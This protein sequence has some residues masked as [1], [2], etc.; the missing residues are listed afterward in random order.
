[1]N[2]KKKYGEYQ[3]FFENYLDNFLADY[4]KKSVSSTIFESVVYS[5]KNGG[6]R[7][8]PV[9][10][11][12]TAEMLGLSLNDV[13]NYALSIE[14]IHSYS[15]VHDDLPAMDNDDYRR[16]K[17]STH[18]KFGEAI[19]ILT[20]DALLNLAAEVL[21]SKTNCTK[22]ELIAAKEI[23]SAAGMMGMISGQVFDIESENKSPSKMLLNVIYENKTAKLI[24][25]PLVVPAILSGKYIEKLRSFGTSAGAL[26]Q[27]V[28][29]IFDYE[30]EL[31]VLGKT[32]HKD[33]NKVTAVTVFGI[34]GAKEYAKTLY[35]KCK[36][37]LKDI[38]N[39]DFL[40]Q[41]ID[42][43]FNRKY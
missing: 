27:V 15:L 20:G 24:T 10:C 16:G 21:L 29:D 38:P 23:M 1:M 43:F 2:F 6:K 12:A 39:S 5:L 13:I 42:Y 4:E 31:A 37:I 36:S 25:V 26:F 30:G 33:E 32:P 7:V 11:L 28:D 18:K 41:T 14:F 40:S 35:D 17:L 19:G 3:A 22:N 34:K 9:L 8:R